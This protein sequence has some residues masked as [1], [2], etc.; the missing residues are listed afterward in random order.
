MS[1][2][3][4]RLKLIRKLNRYTLKEKLIMSYHLLKCYYFDMRSKYTRN[5]FT[6]RKFDSCYLSEWVK[7]KLIFYKPE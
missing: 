5:I 3:L 4:I 6:Q 7:F 1:E 2:P